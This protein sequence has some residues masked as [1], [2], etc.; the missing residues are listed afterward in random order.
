VDATTIEEG[1]KG[2]Q[3]QRHDNEFEKTKGDT[4][5]DAFQMSARANATRNSGTVLDCANRTTLN[6]FV[7]RC[8]NYS[9]STNG[10]MIEW[11]GG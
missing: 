4:R 9:S 3:I 11:Q 2:D 6:A 10:V 1:N 5:A 7:Q 8:R